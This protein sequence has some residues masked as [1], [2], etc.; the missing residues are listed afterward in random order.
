M[1][2]RILIFLSFGTIL[3][4]SL[5]N[6][7]NTTGC[8]QSTYVVM[9]VGFHTIKNDTTITITM[10]SV[11][12]KG[13]G[14]DSILYNNTKS[15]SQL[16]LPLQ[17]NKSISRFVIRNNATYDTLT[18]YQTNIKQ[19][20]SLE[21]GCEVNFQLDSVKTTKHLIKSVQIVQ[22]NV[23]NQSIENIQIFF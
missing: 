3:T 16:S 10:D 11:W 23:T 7:S 22:K 15:V 8:H 4:L 19:F 5:T 12:V 13:V 20:I 9:T 14:I 21:C 17:E 6:C 18:C 2:K 1:M